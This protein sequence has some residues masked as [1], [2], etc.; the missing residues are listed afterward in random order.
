MIN[1]EQKKTFYRNIDISVYLD[2]RY[3]KFFEKYAVEDHSYYWNINSYAAMQR[4]NILPINKAFVVQVASL[5]VI[6]VDCYW[7]I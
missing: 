7:D 3:C 1:T 4:I 5:L 6:E 2:K